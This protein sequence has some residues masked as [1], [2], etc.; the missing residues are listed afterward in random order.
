RV[1]VE[2]AQGAPPNVPFWR[3]EAPARTAELSAC[4]SE[5]REQI[6][7]SAASFAANGDNSGAI[8]TGRHPALTWLCDE[9]GLDDAGA[10]QAV[11]YVV[12]GRTALGAVP[13]QKLVVAE[14]FF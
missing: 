12:A 14:R 6:G 4:V 13:S 9:C 2:D 5:L 11:E 7:A 10:Q 3:G 8:A 1:L